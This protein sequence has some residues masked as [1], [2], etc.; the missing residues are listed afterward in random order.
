MLPKF[1]IIEFAPFPAQAMLPGPLF[2][3]YSEFNSYGLIGCVRPMSEGCP[4]P[5]RF[6][7]SALL[8]SRTAETLSALALTEVIDLKL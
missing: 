2:S 8:P 1:F 6:E 5:G 4:E 7:S 3:L